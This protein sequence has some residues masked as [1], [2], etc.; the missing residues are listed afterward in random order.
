MFIKARHDRSRTRLRRGQRTVPLTGQ[1]NKI[2]L[3]HL[4]SIRRYQTWKDAGS[5]NDDRKTRSLFPPR[6]VGFLYSNKY[7]VACQPILLSIVSICTYRII[8]LVFRIS[9]DLTSLLLGSWGSTPPVRS[10]RGYRV[11]RRRY[12]PLQFW[13]ILP[14]SCLDSW[15]RLRPC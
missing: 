9:A 8:L 10:N 13:G 4:H 12:R 2:N 7:V 14:C 6:K 11:S 3:V 15:F 1:T 5:Q